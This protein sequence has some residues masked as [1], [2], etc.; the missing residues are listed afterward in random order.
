MH[1][2]NL[3]FFLR[4]LVESNFPRLCPA[5][6][7]ST[8]LSE[9]LKIKSQLLELGLKPMQPDNW[10]QM[11]QNA[12]E[13]LQMLTQL[14]ISGFGT[15][16]TRRDAVDEALHR[17]TTQPC[18]AAMSNT[19]R[20]SSTV[21]KFAKFFTCLLSFLKNARVQLQPC[22]GISY[23]IPK[24]NRREYLWN[25]APQNPHHNLSWNLTEKIFAFC[26]YGGVD[27]R[28][29]WRRREPLV[30]ETC[31]SLSL[32]SVLSFW[33]DTNKVLFRRAKGML[34]L[35]LR[36]GLLRRARYRLEEPETLN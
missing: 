26:E 23:S 22:L 19:R 17:F 32:S 5:R 35:S 24:A 25:E 15:R 8:F 31:L 4:L 13:V 6:K 28:T 33:C 20:L 2:Q 18:G 10:I 21:S 7:V 3:H 9:P 16:S 12:E 30:K 36:N 34:K 14:R 1:Q 27:G 29:P 11:E